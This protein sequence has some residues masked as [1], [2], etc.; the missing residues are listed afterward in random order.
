MKSGNEFL[1]ETP[2]KKKDAKTARETRDIENSLHYRNEIT[3]MI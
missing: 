1:K 3:K 2:E